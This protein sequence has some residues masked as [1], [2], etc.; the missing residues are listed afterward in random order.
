MYL[1]ELDGKNRH[2]IPNISASTRPNFT[3]LTALV[4]PYM[5]IIKLK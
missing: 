5:Q 4:G 3:N 1:L 2:I